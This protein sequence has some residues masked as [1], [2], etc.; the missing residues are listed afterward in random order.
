MYTNTDVTDL[1]VNCLHKINLEKFQSVA[2]YGGSILFFYYRLDKSVEL[3]VM[4][5][6]HS[7]RIIDSCCKS[8]NE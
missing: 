8:V 4:I 2:V 3:P 6:T 7:C 5:E 1:K